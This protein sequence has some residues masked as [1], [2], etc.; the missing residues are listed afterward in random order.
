MFTTVSYK[1]AACT[2]ESSCLRPHVL[3][4]LDKYP[5]HHITLY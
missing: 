5:P 3:A 2:F 4:M 1:L